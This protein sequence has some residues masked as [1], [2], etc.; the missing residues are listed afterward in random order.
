[1]VWIIFGP[2]KGLALPLAVSINVGAMLH[3]FKKNSLG[4]ATTKSAISLELFLSLVW[5]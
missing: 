3:G 1:M 2:S 4:K 5:N